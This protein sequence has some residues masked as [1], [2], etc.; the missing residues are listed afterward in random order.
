MKVNSINNNVY[1][2]SHNNANIA[3]DRVALTTGKTGSLN[4]TSGSVAFRGSENS[5]SKRAWFMFRKLSDYMK[6][7]SEMTN[8]EIAF[9]GTGGIAPFAIMCSPRK[10]DVVTDEDK[11]KDREKKWFQAMRQPVSALLAFGF[12]VPT[13]IG[14]AMGFNHMAYNKHW[15]FFNDK[16]L[17]TLIPDEKYLTK[18]AASVWKGKANPELQAK[19]ADVLAKARANEAIYMQELKEQ[20]RKEY[21]EGR[22]QISDEKLEKLV[23]KKRTKNKFFAGKMAGLMRDKLFEEKVQELSSKKFNIKDLDLVTEDY[24]NLAKQRYKEEFTKLRKDAKLNIFDKFISS[25][26]ISNKK[27]NNLSN[28]EKDLAKAKGLELIKQAIANKEIPDVLNDPV[29][30]LRNFIKNKDK[31]AQ[32]LYSNKIFWLTLVTNLFMVGISCVALNWLHP[33]FA[34]F[35]D[36]IKERRQAAKM[37]GQTKV[38]VEA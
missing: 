4:E 14:I 20:K 26:G 25:I 33:K 34:D 3:G 35:V 12:Q 32:K 1:Q 7:P 22:M 23:N 29:A 18:Q 21:Y 6:S 31:N 36:K 27:L 28:A 11:K 15:E 17:G 30:K 9:I 38:E 19:W 13:T 8:A 10:K 16:T 2:K 37:E 5:L 24:Q